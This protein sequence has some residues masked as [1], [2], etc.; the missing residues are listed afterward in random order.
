MILL[1]TEES[2]VR[3][4]CMDSLARVMAII[5]YLEKHPKATREQ[6]Y[7]DLELEEY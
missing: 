4:L 1:V 5:R 2:F 3:R 6:C 7:T